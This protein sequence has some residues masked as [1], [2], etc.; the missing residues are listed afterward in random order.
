[1]TGYPWSDGQTLYA[2]DLDAAFASGQAATAAAQDAANTA[3]TIANTAQTAATAAQTAATAAQAAAAAATSADMAVNVLTAGAKGDG[4]TDDSPAIQAALNAMA[5]KG[6]GIVYC[7][8][9]GR[10]YL[11]HTGLTVPGGVK[12][13]GSGTRNLQGGSINIPAWCAVGTWLQCTDTTNSAVT[14]GTTSTPAHGASVSGVNFIYSQ[15]TPG[16]T[17]TPTDYPFAVL[18][19]SDH[20][21]IEDVM[22][23]GATRGVNIQAPNSFGIGAGISLRNIFLSVYLRGLRTFGVNDTITIDGLWVNDQTFAAGLSNP[24]AASYLINNLVGWEVDYCDNPLVNNMYLFLCRFGMLLTDETFLGNTHSLYNAC[25]SNLQTVLCRTAISVATSST[26]ATGSFTNWNAQSYTGAT[27]TLFNLP[28]DNVDFSIAN[29]TVPSAG[30]K[31]LEFGGGT[32]GKLNIDGLN[33]GTYSAVSTGQPALQVNAG[34]TLVLGNRTITKFGGNGQVIAGAGSGGIV[35]GEN[36][37]WHVLP[38]ALASNVTANG[39]AQSV[40]LENDFNPVAT[41]KYQARI[42]GSFQVVTP[43]GSGTA[44]VKLQNFPEI[45]AA[46]I[47]CTSAASVIFDSNWIDISSVTNVTGTVQVAATSGVV[48]NFSALTVQFR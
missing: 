18:I 37:L 33:V 32:R 10:P 34:A 6:G 12:L 38:T 7:P 21:T 48:Y 28:S 40:C 11:L 43:Q 42:S 14:L 39:A 3:K 36:L 1:M 20:V 23:V 9:T 24:V 44:T 13:L 8:P 5:A 29:L 46:G 35:S 30:G 17:W 41:G 15:P 31:L 19:Q 26:T 4:A 25:I 27:D 22:V 45:A 16:S 47:N 2:N